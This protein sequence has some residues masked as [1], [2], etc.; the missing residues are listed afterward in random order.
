MNPEVKAWWLTALR[1][2]E[3]EQGIG[4]LVSVSRL[5]NKR[6]CCLGVLCDIQEKAGYPGLRFSNGAVG[7]SPPGWF[8]NESFETAILPVVMAEDLGLDFS[9]PTIPVTPE[10]RADPRLHTFRSQQSQQ[11]SLR[12]NLAALN[13]HGFSFLEIA[14]IIEAHL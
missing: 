7:H 12:L 14:D 5:G 6:Y 4:K 10:L 11:Y 13:D 9:N 3:Y 1:S 8:L 2:G